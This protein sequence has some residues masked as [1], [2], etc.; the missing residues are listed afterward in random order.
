[1]ANAGASHIASTFR[2][3]GP[4]YTLA[5]ACSSSTHAIG[6]AFWLIRQ[7]IVAKAITGGSEA[8]C[9]F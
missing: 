7:G 3:M 9:W 1:M 6:H 5:T 8:P 4:T 2:I